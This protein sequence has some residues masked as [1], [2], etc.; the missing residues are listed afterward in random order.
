MDLAT[1]LAQ[2]P[3][4]S[5][6]SIQSH[7]GFYKNFQ[8]LGHLSDLNL[9]L[10]KPTSLAFFTDESKSPLKKRKRIKERIHSLVSI[11]SGYLDR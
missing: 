4:L 2:N 1:S 3:V 8:T 6:V 5:P 9:N 11:F 10:P 7:S